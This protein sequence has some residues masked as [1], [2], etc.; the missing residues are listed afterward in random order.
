MNLTKYFNATEINPID[1]INIT[2]SQSYP[3]IPK[4]ATGSVTFT[5]DVPLLSSGVYS[6][7]AST[8]RNTG[9]GGNGLIVAGVQIA[10]VG[11]NLPCVPRSRHWKM[12]SSGSMKVSNIPY[13][14]SSIA[15][16][17]GFRVSVVAISQ[18]VEAYSSHE[19][20]ATI[21]YP[22]EGSPQS[23]KLYFNITDKEIFTTQNKHGNLPLGIYFHET[24]RS[25][26]PSTDLE[27]I[28]HT[29]LD[30][31]RDDGMIENVL[32]D[33][34]PLTNIYF[35]TYDRLTVNY[36]TMKMVAT[37]I[38]NSLNIN[39]IPKHFTA[40]VISNNVPIW[41]GI[42]PI[43][44]PSIEYYPNFVVVTE[45][46]KLAS[47]NPANIL[48]H[49]SQNGTYYH[50]ESIMWDGGTHGFQF[51][52]PK[53]VS[54]FYFTTDACTVICN[55]TAAWLPLRDYITIV[56]DNNDTMLKMLPYALD[57]DSDTCFDLPVPGDSPSMLWMIITKLS[58]FG[59]TSQRFV[60]RITGHDIE[61]GN[62]GQKSIH[63]GT[64]GPAYNHQ[65]STESDVIFCTL[66]LRTDNATMTQCD[67]ECECDTLEQCSNVHIFMQSTNTDVWS[68]CE[69]S[70]NDVVDI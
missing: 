64:S 50:Q 20:S 65:C 27:L 38:N 14:T 69:L 16:K 57:Q 46:V 3:L 6:I 56:Q 23:F 31:R 30:S 54:H 37:F 4:S 12:S 42:V 17:F 11:S 40:R 15:N 67:I 2:A 9:P 59:V 70:I 51:A 10:S 28:L 22:G 25:V 26:T 7:R 58:L 68:L 39:N 53:V 8:K 48:Y 52:F 35:A 47:T 63:V 32:V 45:I 66:L 18:L 19:L 29:R 1:K 62:I 60:V 44:H 13:T 5:W 21:S 36:V 41:T 43:A 49:Y 33:I 34:S 61:C 55:V 24:C